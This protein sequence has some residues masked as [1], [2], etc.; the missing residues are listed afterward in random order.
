ME[1]E[2]DDPKFSFVL[3]AEKNQKRWQLMEKVWLFLSIIAF[4]VLLGSAMYANHLFNSEVN[5][6]SRIYQTIPSFWWSGFTLLMI[7]GYA[8]KNI[9]KEM[10]FITSMKSSIKYDSILNNPKTDMRSLA[11]ERLFN[12][13]LYVAGYL[14]I[15]IVAVLISFSLAFYI[16]YPL[17]LVSESKLFGLGSIL[18]ILGIAMVYMYHYF[19]NKL[20]RGLSAALAEYQRSKRNEVK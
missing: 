5:T 19:T 15:F 8:L 16:D 6:H 11:K 2:L 9:C 4:F 17:A 18:L 20:N 12:S 14:C 10:S 3:Q 1:N 7:G 13:S